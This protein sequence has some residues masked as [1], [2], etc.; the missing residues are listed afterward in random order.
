MTDFA[1]GGPG[2]GA[3]CWKGLEFWSSVM[4]VCPRP[5]RQLGGRMKGG[6]GGWEFGAVV[7]GDEPSGSILFAQISEASAVLGKRLGISQAEARAK[8]LVYA[9]THRRG[10]PA[11]AA[12]VMSGVLQVEDLDG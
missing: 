1:W 2:L 8:M 4:S 5:W 3:M 12:D 7:D 10:L 11:V 9:N 6:Q